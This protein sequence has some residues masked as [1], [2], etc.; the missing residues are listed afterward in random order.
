VIAL[1]TAVVTLIFIAGLTFLVLV[2]AAVRREDRASRLPVEAPGRVTAIGRRV[3]GLHV[4][5]TAGNVPGRRGNR[6]A[7]R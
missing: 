4:R 2:I 3:A 6:T 5:R 7:R 1:L